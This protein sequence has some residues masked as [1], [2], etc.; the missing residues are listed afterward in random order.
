MERFFTDYWAFLATVHRAI[1]AF[2]LRFMF[3]CCCK[4]GL[5]FFFICGYYVNVC[6]LPDFN[7]HFYLRFFLY[8]KR[9]GSAFDIP[10]ISLP[11]LCV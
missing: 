3:C 10:K 2:T 11:Y 6:V 5:R 7:W 8:Q 1:G 4:K 9:R